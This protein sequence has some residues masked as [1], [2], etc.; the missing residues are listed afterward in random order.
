MKH[1]DKMDDIL[2]ASL[3]LFSSKGYIQTSMNDIADALN[4]TKGGLYH[5]LDKKEDALILIHNQMTNAF[6]KSSKDSIAAAS[7][8]RDKLK[9]WIRAHAYLMKKYSP[10]VNIFFTQLNFLKNSNEFDRIVSKRDDIFNLLLDIIREGQKQKKFRDDIH[11][12]IAAFLICGM[13]NWFYQWYH[14]DGPLGIENII[15]DVQIL[16]FDGIEKKS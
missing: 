6:L 9:N 3:S 15:E 10:H 2:A 5:Y 8:P 4:M 12:R 7:D 11:P 14:P 13:L 16:V 1:K